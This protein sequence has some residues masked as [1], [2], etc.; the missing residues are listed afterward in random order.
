M[1]DIIEIDWKEV[2]M[3]WNGNKMKLP[4]SVVIPLRDKFTIRRIIE[5]E[6]L[7]FHVMLKQG[8]TWFP[9]LVK[10]SQEAV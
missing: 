9:L 7:L 4:T 6:P 5:R 8:M 1:W 3:T 10:D 2:N